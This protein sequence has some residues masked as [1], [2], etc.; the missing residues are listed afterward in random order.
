MLS[1][2]DRVIKTQKELWLARNKK[3][4]LA[5]SISYLERFYE[6]VETS[7][8]YITKKEKKYEKN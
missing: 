2:K 3:G 5:K 6:F 4:G 8:E 7:I 1:D